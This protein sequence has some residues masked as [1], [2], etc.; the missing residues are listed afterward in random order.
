MSE[1]R[2][3]LTI[4]AFD[5]VKGVGMFCIV[6]GHTISRYQNSLLIINILIRILGIGMMPMFFLISGIGYKKTNQK[7]LVKKLKKELLRPYLYVTIAT[8]LL[9]PL[10]HYLAFQWLPGAVK[11]GIRTTLAYLTGSAKSGKTI[12]GISIYECSVIWFFLAL[13]WASLILNSILRFDEKWKQMVMV[14]FCVIAGFVCSSLNIWYFCIPQGLLA[15]GYMYFGYCIKRS[16]WLEKK[17]KKWQLIVL[18]VIS[19]FEIIYGETNLAYLI[20]KGGIFDYVG[21]GLTGLFM[22]C[23]ALQLNQYNG[24]IAEIVAKI[25]RYT[26]YA[27]CVHSVEINCIPWYLLSEK[28]THYQNVGLFL[29][30]FLRSCILIVACKIINRITTYRRKQKRK[31]LCTMRNI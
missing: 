25:G 31:K 19:A 28:F 18:G 22:I 14:C 29:E 7:K 15:V 6:V 17:W 20:F 27:M 12:F 16:G 13:F 3:V 21:A 11:E 9:F 24:T 23:I 10:C 30:V 1:K 8:T 4:G 26:Y 2:R 5:L